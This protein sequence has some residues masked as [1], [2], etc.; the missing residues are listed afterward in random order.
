[1]MFDMLTRIIV[2]YIVI[3]AACYAFWMILEGTK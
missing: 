3:A 2:W 1:M